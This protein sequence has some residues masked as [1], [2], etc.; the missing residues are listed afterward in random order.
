MPYRWTDH[1]P[2]PDAPLAELQLWPHRS[3]PPSGFVTFFAITAALVAVPLVAVIG[4]PVL[5]GVL[6]FIM[7]TFAAMWWG[8]KR[9]WADRAVVEQL[10]L[11]TDRMT[12]V[13]SGPRNVRKEWEANP[14]WV[15]LTLYPKGGP[16]KNYLTLSGAGREVEIGAF[17]SEEER[18]TLYHDLDTQL[19]SL[20]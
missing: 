18:K 7:A 17:L 6:P 11:W 1:A 12:L 3:L 20:R 2:S 15:R 14:H 4:S 5:W 13:H 9:S 16:V 8:L 19:R 10:T